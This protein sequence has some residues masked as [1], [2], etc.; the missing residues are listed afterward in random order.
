M[1]RFSPSPEVADRVWARLEGRIAERKKH[2]WGSH[3]WKPWAHPGGWVLLAACLCVAFTGVTYQR[4]Q[5]ENDDLASYLMAISNPDGY[6]AHDDDLVNVTLL[7][8]EPSGGI[9]EIPSPEEDHLN[10][11]RGDEIFL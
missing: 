8:S 6:L 2:F 5:A 9:T 11:L 4:N 10:V 1:G 7:L 3:V